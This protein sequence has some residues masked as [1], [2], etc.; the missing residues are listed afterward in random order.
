MSLEV[1]FPN[2][3]NKRPYPYVR[4]VIDYVNDGSGGYLEYD[5]YWYRRAEDPLPRELTLISQR[6]A[7]EPYKVRHD[8]S[9]GTIQYYITSDWHR[10]RIQ[11]VEHVELQDTSEYWPDE[12]EGGQICLFPTAR[13]RIVFR[14]L[15]K[16][17][18]DIVDDTR[19][20]RTWLSEGESTENK[21]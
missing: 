14:V 18:W 7:K 17:K 5:G 3:L 1:E 13:Q 2:A 9:G 8:A 10:W 4:E 12:E 6:V 20:V 15:E 11:V 19:A 21:E 16:L